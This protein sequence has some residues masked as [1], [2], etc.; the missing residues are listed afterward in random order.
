M[1][2]LLGKTISNDKYK[3]LAEAFGAKLKL[4]SADAVPAPRPATTG[5]IEKWV[6]KTVGGVVRDNENR[7][8]Q[9][10]AAIPDTFTFD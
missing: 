5:E 8:R 10:E 2:K 7:K 3:I 9:E 6:A 1:A 4:T